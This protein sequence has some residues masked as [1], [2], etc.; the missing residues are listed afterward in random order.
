[1]AA[2]EREVGPTARNPMVVAG[3]LALVAAAAVLV[4]QIALRPLVTDLAM[5]VFGTLD[6]DA[7]GAAARD[8]VMTLAL[9]LFTA[10]TTGKNALAGARS[11]EV[12]VGGR[13]CGCRSRDT[14]SPEC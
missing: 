3:G 4:L 8:R 2:P 1:M 7:P 9:V 14:R 12:S 11:R 6:L 13:R 5:Q 10:L